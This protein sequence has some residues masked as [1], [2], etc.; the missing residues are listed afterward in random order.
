MGT[1]IGQIKRDDR[2]F[3]LYRSH[4]LLHQKSHIKNHKNQRP[5]RQ[6]VIQI[7]AE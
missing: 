3:F 2:G 1:R 7:H 6:A 4:T 5:Q